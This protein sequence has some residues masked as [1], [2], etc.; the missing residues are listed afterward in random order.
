MNQIN[1]MLENKQ[2]K[3][4]GGDIQ[5]GEWEYNMGA[6]WSAFDQVNLMGEIKSI[7][8]QTEESVK[9]LPETAAWGLA[10]GLV[11]GPLGALAGVVLGG[12]RKNVCALC[13]LKDGRKFLATMD[14]KVYQ[15]MLAM[16]MTHK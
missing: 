12:N 10:G 8:L 15:D 2:V 14:Q 4:L 13:E 11:F 6:L 1:K 7:Q 3:V 5:A 16:S 9:R